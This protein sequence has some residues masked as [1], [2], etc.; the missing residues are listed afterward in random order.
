MK[1]PIAGAAGG[2]VVPVDGGSTDYWTTPAVSDYS[3]SAPRSS[4]TR[5][6]GL[7]GRGS[8]SVPCSRGVPR[9]RWAW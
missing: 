8:A 4:V 6:P 5:W 9:C 7:G 3:E 1:K 2:A